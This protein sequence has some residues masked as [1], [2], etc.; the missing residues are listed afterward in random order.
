M[1]K[2]YYLNLDQFEGQ[3]NL[4]E[5]HLPYLKQFCSE[6]DIRGK[7]ILEVG[8]AMPSEIV[9]D[10]LQANSWTCVE[11]PMY[12]QVLGM[13]G[14]QQTISEAKNN[15]RYKVMLKNIEDLDISFNNTFD[16]IF[17]IAC[18]E[19]VSRLSEALNK[20]WSVLKPGGRLFSMFSP[21]WSCYDGH[22]LYHLSLPERF[23]QSQDK[24]ILLP[25]E[26]LLKTRKTLHLDLE[27]RFDAEFADQVIYE[28]FNN[29]HINRHFAE[30]YEYIFEKSPFKLDKFFP[31][32][33]ASVPEAYQAILEQT[34]FSYKKF[35]NM[36]YYVFIS[37]APA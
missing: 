36:G 12:D 10:F 3:F 11:D 6:Y 28:V 30:D 13:V 7:D 32:Y 23:L 34:C 27:S 22:H 29:P 1:T 5:Y 14:N 15:K 37:K 19:H 24:K 18:F 16:C 21:I 8:G 20:M 35:S 4:L 2:P 17:S 9:I 33:V 26:H 25:W 31:S